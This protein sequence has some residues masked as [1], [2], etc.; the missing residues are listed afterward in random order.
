VDELLRCV[1]GR[2][3]NQPDHDLNADQGDHRAQV[4]TDDW[5]DPWSQQS[6]YRG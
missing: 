5:E 4:E 1:A 2:H 6:G 3:Q